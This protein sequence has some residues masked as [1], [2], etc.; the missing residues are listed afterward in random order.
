MRWLLDVRRAAGLELTYSL[1]SLEVNST[2]PDLPFEEAAPTYGRALAALALARRK[3]G[4][5]GFES[6][7]LRIG[8]RLHDRK[9]AMSKEL[10][11]DALAAAE[12]PGLTNE[13][14]RQLDDLAAEVI[15]SY[16]AAR[17]RDV[18]GVPTLAIEDDKVI[19]G[20]VI[21]V[22]PTGQ[23]GLALWEQVRGLADRDVFFELKRWP[24]DVRP[25]GRPTGPS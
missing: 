18:F 15:E 13:V 21:A 1:F 6:L 25:G 24:R 4:D 7:Y 5:D 3:E 16:R 20:P 19:Y 2:D 12:Y 9:E 10:L 14:E 8:E 22:A 11:T 17:E 23:D